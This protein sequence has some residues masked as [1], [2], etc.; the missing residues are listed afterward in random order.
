VYKK[1]LLLTMGFGM[2]TLGVTGITTSLVDQE[3]KADLQQIEKAQQETVA[4]AA[5]AR[6]MLDE[7]RQEVGKM[8]QNVDAERKRVEEERRAVEKERRALDETYRSKMFALEMQK[9]ALM[10]AKTAPPKAAVKGKGDKNKTKQTALSGKGR[11]PEKRT[12]SAAGDRRGRTAAA[13]RAPVQD[14]ALRQ[15]ARKAGF[16]AARLFQPVQYQSRRTGELIVAEP[17]DYGPGSVRV[18]VRVWKSQRLVQDTVM[19][20]SE[21]LLHRAGR[22]HA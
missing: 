4:A 12:V 15:V 8:T 13:S 11:K 21:A 20:F 3:T 2:I 22:P 10:E 19:S 6:R 16:Q 14:E 17:Y 9:R 5:E 7:K 1:I 18:R